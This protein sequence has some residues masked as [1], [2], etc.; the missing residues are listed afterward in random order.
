MCVHLALN[1]SSR[2][3]SN[4]WMEKKIYCVQQYD[5]QQLT[6]GDG[7]VF[8]LLFR[9]RLSRDVWCLAVCCIDFQN[10]KEISQAVKQTGGIYE[11]KLCFIAIYDFFLI[12]YGY[13][14]SD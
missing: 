2:R 12:N 5:L 9:L 4:V 7:G 1:E 6:A 11:M 13:F 8:N 3:L 10:D 14:I